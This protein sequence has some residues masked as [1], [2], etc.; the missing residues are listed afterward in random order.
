MSNVIAP[1]TVVGN[2]LEMQHHQLDKENPR[3]TRSSLLCFT[4]KKSIDNTCLWLVPSHFQQVKTSNT[5]VFIVLSKYLI[6]FPVGY[7]HIN[8]LWSHIISIILHT[9][10]L[11]LILM[12]WHR[13][14]IFE[15][16]RDKSYSSAG[17]RVRTLEVWNTKSPAD[18]IPT[19]K[20]TELSKI[21]KMDSIA[22]PYDEWAFSSLKVGRN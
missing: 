15:S 2:Y 5:S 8:H 7:M 4:H 18:W 17:C 21:K 20:V 14:A 3:I 12:F 22:R 10:L 16:R 9:F 6:T 11:L 13:Q 1:S 19:H